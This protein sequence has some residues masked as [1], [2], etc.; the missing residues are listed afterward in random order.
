[1]KIP[2]RTPLNSLEAVLIAYVLGALTA[3]S[4]SAYGEYIQR[5]TKSR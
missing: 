1:M 3:L 4:F 5:N 2:S